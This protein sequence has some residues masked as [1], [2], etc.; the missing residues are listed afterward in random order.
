MKNR[1]IN[2]KKN[3]MKRYVVRKNN[4]EV[5]LLWKAHTLD[6]LHSAGMSH[7]FMSYRKLMDL[8]G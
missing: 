1:K 4:V 5:D 2:H 8:L 6:K 3:K 7:K